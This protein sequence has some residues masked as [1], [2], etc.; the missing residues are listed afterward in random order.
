[1]F[2]DLISYLPQL[3]KSISHYLTAFSLILPLRLIQQWQPKSPHPRRS[4][5]HQLQD[6]AS[7]TNSTYEQAANSLSNLKMNDSPIKKLDFS[8][9]DKENIPVNSSIPPTEESSVMKKSIVEM[10]KPVETLKVASGIKAQ[11]MDE[12]LL[13]ENP[14]RFVLFP[15]KYHEVRV[16]HHAARVNCL[17]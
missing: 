5:L 12:P 15:I 10:V 6:V 9:T 7:I 13:Q 2:L 4:V 8:A 17:S 16:Y 14:H 11:E 1:L 3:F